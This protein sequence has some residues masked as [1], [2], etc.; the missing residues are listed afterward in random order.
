MPAPKGQRGDLS[1]KRTEFGRNSGKSEMTPKK[2]FPRGSQ[3]KN[4]SGQYTERTAFCSALF[5]RFGEI[6]GR[7]TYGQKNSSL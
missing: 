3:G 4:L 2:Q 1:G 6:Y 5:F 7:K